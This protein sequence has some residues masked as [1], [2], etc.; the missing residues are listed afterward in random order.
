MVLGHIDQTTT[1]A[2]LGA[3]PALREALRW[4]R[5]HYPEYPE[6]RTAL[7]GDQLYA[8]THAYAT[9]PREQCRWESHRHTAD[10]QLCVAG[11]EL[12]DWTSRTPAV[13]SE[14]YDADKD[15]ELWPAP[16]PASET[17]HLI[18]G[19]FAIFL[20]GELHRPM[21]HDGVH[22]QVSKLVLKIRQELFPTL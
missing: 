7:Q 17:A 12:I 6:G 11:G 22:H 13:S 19:R 8:V 9:R 4:L 15:F 20:P 18:P 5:R 2:L 3:T 14:Q 21:G 16:T 10:L 1:L